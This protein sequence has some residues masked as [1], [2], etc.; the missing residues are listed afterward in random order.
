MPNLLVPIVLALFVPAAYVAM[1]RLGPRSGV[2]VALLGGWL[3]LPVFDG[4]LDIPVL[5]GKMTFVSTTILMVSLVADFASWRRL[6]LHWV[7]LFAAMVCLS[8][9][10]TA[11]SNDLGAYEGLSAALQSSCAWIAPYLLGRV[12]LGTPRAIA[13]FA[14]RMT[15]G[16]LVYVPLCLWEIRMSPQLHRQLYGYATIENFAFVVR[17]GG[18]RPTVFMHFG[19]MV[20]TFM[21][22]GALVAY[23]LWRCRSVPWIWRLRTSSCTA[24][25]VLTTVLVKSTGAVILLA[26]GIAILEATRLSRR[27][28]LP[29][30]LLA[31]APLAFVTARISGWSGEEY[32]KVAGA[33]SPDRAQSI[34]FRIGNE[35]LLIGKAMQRPWLGW[36]RWGRSR[37]YDDEGKDISVTD[38]LWVILLGGNGIVGLG[39]LALLM[40]VPTLLLLRRFPARGWSHPSLAPAAALTLSAVLWVV[41]CLFNAM[42]TPL[43]PAISGAT[44]TL[45]AARWSARRRAVPPGAHCQTTRAAAQPGSP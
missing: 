29:I 3:F 34:S 6:E 2:M 22:T 18:Y 23:W 42:T 13:E 33:I 10:A 11:L 4:R 38:S 30:V 17:F 45:L 19:L 15:G 5:A 35:Q 9:F 39:A 40:L 41:D 32:V 20:G 7:D 12:Y 43:F 25:L 26:L 8:P 36:G 21:G 27:S 28:L 37:I 1:R 16:A 31:I 14:R 44:V 24:L